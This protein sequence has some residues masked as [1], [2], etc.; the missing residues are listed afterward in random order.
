ME[1][2]RHS[3]KTPW[4]YALLEER[5]REVAHRVHEGGPGAL[6]LSELAPVITLGRRAEEAREL[7]LSRE[8]LTRR[9]IEVLKTA[10]GGLATWHGPGQWVIFAVDRLDRLTGDRRGVRLAV[11]GLLSA[12]LRVCQSLCPEATIRDGSET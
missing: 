8:V 10:R 2:R 5:Q 7:R 11:Q 6:L 3:A 9:G 1:I 12:A 4:T